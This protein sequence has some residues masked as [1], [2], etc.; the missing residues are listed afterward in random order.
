MKIGMPQF[1]HIAKTVADH[2]AAGD[3][4]ISV[5]TKKRS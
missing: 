1:A 2:Q 5:D 3:L 4:V